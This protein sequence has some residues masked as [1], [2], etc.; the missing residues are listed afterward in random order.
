MD[1]GVSSVVVTDR[2]YS[3]AS[4]ISNM[5]TRTRKSEMGAVFSGELGEGPQHT[6]IASVFCVSMTPKS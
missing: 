5:P 3:V 4:V 2:T 6:S 1:S